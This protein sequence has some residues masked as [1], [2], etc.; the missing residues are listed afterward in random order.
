V[1][2][3]ASKVDGVLVEP[4]AADVPVLAEA[5]RR[6]LDWY[7]RLLPIASEEARQEPN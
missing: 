5:R 4:V 6:W 1:E 2:L 7:D 3:S